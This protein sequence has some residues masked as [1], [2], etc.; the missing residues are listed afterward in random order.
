[1][2]LVCPSM[3]D[4][5]AKPIND[6]LCLAASSLIR[7][8]PFTPPPFPRFSLFLP[9]ALHHDQHQQLVVKHQQSS[10]RMTSR[11]SLPSF[12]YHKSDEDNLEEI[13]HLGYDEE[14]SLITG[15]NSLKH[16]LNL[17]GTSTSLSTAAP[18]N[19][20]K[21]AMFPLS[22]SLCGSL[23]RFQPKFLNWVLLL[24]RYTHG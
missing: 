3:I 8:F 16:V 22:C 9:F 21:P 17:Q 24:F 1:M 18:V 13:H 2:R 19:A 14:D 15:T 4:W 5:N 6:F 12:R 20:R 11:N 10:E 7:H 23:T